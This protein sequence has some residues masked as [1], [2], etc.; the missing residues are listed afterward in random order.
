MLW[1]WHRARLHRQ[2]SKE[3]TGKREIWQGTTGAKCSRR[4]KLRRGAPAL[5]NP[6]PAQPRDVSPRM[7]ARLWHTIHAGGPRWTP[8]PGTPPHSTHPVAA[9]PTPSRRCPPLPGTQPL[10]APLPWLSPA[11][12]HPNLPYI[13]HPLITPAS[14]PSQNIP[15]LPP[16]R[17]HPTLHPLRP[18]PTLRPPPHP[19]P[20]RTTKRPGPQPVGAWGFA[21]GFGGRMKRAAGLGPPLQA[22]LWVQG[23]AVQLRARPSG[24]SSAG[25]INQ[26]GLDRAAAHTARAFIAH[27]IHSS[28]AG[29]SRGPGPCAAGGSASLCTRASG[30]RVRRS[31]WGG[32]SHGEGGG[33]CPELSRG[34]D[35]E[36]GME[37]RRYNPER[38]AGGW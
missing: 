16:P 9:A 17:E 13:T 27:R 6:P 28:A 2:P 36:R 34:S 35:R 26:R 19:Q 22:A 20:P 38:K 10:C 4:H 12:P 11:T 15:A 30:Q 8:A 23:T 21:P 29:A 31:W 18:H 3:Y 5:C 32:E 25:N 1:A 37:G 7:A 14:S 24:Q 33:H